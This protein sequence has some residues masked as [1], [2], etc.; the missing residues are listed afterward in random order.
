[1]DVIEEGLVLRVDREELEV[2]AFLVVLECMVYQSSERRLLLI[3]VRMHPPMSTL[4]LVS[5]GLG[6]MYLV[7]VSLERPT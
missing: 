5:L 7:V 4:I 6:S 3:G 2:R 1:M